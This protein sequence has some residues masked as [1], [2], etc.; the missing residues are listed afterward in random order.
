MC[1]CPLS[2]VPSAPLFL[3]FSFFVFFFFSPPFFF[4]LLVRVCVFASSARLFFFS[5]PFFPFRS[6]SP[7]CR[8]LLSFVPF[9][10]CVRGGF[11]W[12]A[13]ASARRQSS[14]F[15]FL[16]SS[17]PPSW[18]YARGSRQPLFTGICPP[19]C[20]RLP[21]FVSPASARWLVFASSLLPLPASAR[22]LVLCFFFLLLFSVPLFPFVA[23]PASAGKLVLLFW[24]I[25]VSVFWPCGCCQ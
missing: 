5:L 20:R 4:F 14:P 25:A 17:F 7:S 1:C 21:V 23:S 3:L 22:W 16:A 10:C 12:F 2:P 9:C 24:Q 8:G 19:D 18:G 6:F 15:F 13:S 11:P